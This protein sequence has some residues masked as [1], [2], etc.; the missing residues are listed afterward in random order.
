[1]AGM[2]ID[3]HAVYYKFPP[4]KVVPRSV[5][6]FDFITIILFLIFCFEKVYIIFQTKL[7]WFDSISLFRF[8]LIGVFRLIFGTIKTK[9]RTKLK[10]KIIKNLKLC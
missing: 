9:T 4:T 6:Q 3:M 7:I 8:N 5:F 2:K 1:M 10:Y